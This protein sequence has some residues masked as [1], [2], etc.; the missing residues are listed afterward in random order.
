M[1]LAG[2]F[3]NGQTNQ[4]LLQHAMEKLSFLLPALVFQHRFCFHC[5]PDQ[6][7]NGSQLEPAR[8]IE[9]IL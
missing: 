2:Q 1:S 8:A 9:V 7:L 5:R 6:V 4:V 3:L